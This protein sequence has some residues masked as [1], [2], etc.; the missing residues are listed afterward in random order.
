MGVN[1]ITA[2]NFAQEDNLSIDRDKLKEKLITIKVV[3]ENR[4]QFRP[5]LKSRAFVPLKNFSIQ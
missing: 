2:F 1:K 5:L 3:Q 4:V